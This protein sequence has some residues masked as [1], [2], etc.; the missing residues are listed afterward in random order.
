MIDLLIL[1]ENVLDI[2]KQAW[3]LAQKYV[4]DIDNLQVHIKSSEKDMKTDGSPVTQAD[5][6]I[7]I[8][9]KQALRSLLPWSGFIW[10]ETWNET[11]ESDYTWIIDPIDWTREFSRGMPERSILIALKYKNDIVL[12]ISFMPIIDELI[13]ASLWN[14]A[15]CNWNKLNVSD[16]N[17]EKAYIMHER[18]KYFMRD[19]TYDQFLKL[20][21]QVWYYKSDRTRSYH[22]LA[23]GKIDAV[24]A[25]KQH[26]YDFAPFVCILQEAWWIVT[27]I[28]WKSI[29][30]SYTDAIFSNW[31]CHKK[32][33]DIFSV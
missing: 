9:L 8:F 22:Y 19:G 28:G 20:C 1:Q 26:V 23:Q 11:W 15:W 3:I 33:V 13:Y 27:T 16:R 2:V 12:W 18:H 17:F 32:I 30:D 29:T 24:I 25:P 10:E 6:E 5:T 21:E 14:G 7:E 31:V 4:D